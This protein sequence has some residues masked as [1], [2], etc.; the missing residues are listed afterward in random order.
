MGFFPSEGGGPHID[1]L[2][3]SDLRSP[4]LTELMNSPGMKG[5]VGAVAHE[6]MR[7][8]LAHYDA[9]A[10]QTGNLASTAKV[11]YHRHRTVHDNRWEA[12]FSVGGPRAPYAPELEAEYHLLAQALRDMGYAS[13]DMRVVAPPGRG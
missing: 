4:M 8:Y 13:G 1:P 9:V 6:V 12:E 7:R 10:R 2:L 3:T 5:E 11:T